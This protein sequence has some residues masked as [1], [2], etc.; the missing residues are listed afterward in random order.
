MVS[1]CF[2]S[3]C[4]YRQP[5]GKEIYRKGTLSVYELDGR[6]HKVRPYQIRLR[7]LDQL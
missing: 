7:L 1:I 5:P 2:Q 4:I 3:E 6:D